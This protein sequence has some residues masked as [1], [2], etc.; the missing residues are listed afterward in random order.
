MA[1]S[2]EW[3]AAA[4]KGDVALL[5]TLLKTG[6]GSAT[7]E[8]ACHAIVCAA[9]K[10]QVAAVRLFLDWG[11]PT[12]VSNKA[13]Q[14][15]LHVATS[16]GSAETI[17][18]LCSR[19][20]D[21]NR[22]D[23]NGTSCIT[24]ALKAKKLGV[25]KELLRAGAQLPD[26]DTENPFPGLA[27][28]LQEVQ[29]ERLT[30]ELK[31]AAGRNAV[32]QENLNDID[33]EVWT[34][35][36]EHMRLIRVFEEQKAGSVL[37]TL[38]DKTR[39]MREEEEKAKSLEAQLKKEVET[40]RV[41]LV[42]AESHYNDA[43]KELVNTEAAEALVREEDRLIRGE[44]AEGKQELDSAKTELKQS[45]KTLAGKTDLRERL[46]AEQQVF[47]GESK[48]AH[49]LRDGIRAELEEARDELEGWQA[50]R[51]AAAALTAQAQ[52]LLGLGH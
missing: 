10:N 37:I 38:E 44:L 14:K 30:I 5:Q 52:R 2:D 13:G 35:Q 17:E 46:Q 39:S 48:E 15:L 42:A 7:G 4:E 19:K 21:I 41:Q 26:K 25:I 27:G 3:A 40:I 6:P 31:A 22:L 33:K 8:R 9:A 29:L 12:E 32:S 50:N 34:V 28:V 1:D 45:Q 43:F 36:K 18:L 11:T 47:E 49:S 20:A 24:L 23:H 16:A 51:E